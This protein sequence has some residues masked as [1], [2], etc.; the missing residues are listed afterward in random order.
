MQKKNAELENKYDFIPFTEI[1]AFH[2]SNGNN[3]R[4]FSTI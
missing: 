3:K 1:L 2:S 4:Y